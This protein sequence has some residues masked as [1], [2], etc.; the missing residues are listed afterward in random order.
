MAQAQDGDPGE[1]A[2][3]DVLA[4]VEL[5]SFTG[6]PDHIRP[7]GASRLAWEVKGPEHGFRITLNGTTVARTDHEFVQP[8]S[9]TIYRLHAAAGGATKFLR[10]VTVQVNESACQTDSLFNPQVTIR[11][12]LNTQI[13][14]QK[15]LYFDDDTEVIFSPGT[16]RFKLHLRQR[17]SY[18]PDPTIEI[19]A[20]FGLAVEHGHIVSVVQSVSVDVSV[21]FYAWAIPGAVPAL[22]IAMSMGE[23]DAKRSAQRLIRGI[24]LLI[25]FLA[26]FSNKKLVKHSVRVGVDDNG[27]GTI[28]F[29]GCPNDLLAGLVDISSAGV[30]A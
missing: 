30:L 13:K 11:G 23:D 26:V 16:I 15:D 6:A 3:A 29:Q 14:N 28:D 5:V 17:V 10:A 9:T 25:D 19:D 4:D 8:Q 22:A 24:G 27:F 21:P 12:F 1:S 7:F 18:F 20:S 2:N